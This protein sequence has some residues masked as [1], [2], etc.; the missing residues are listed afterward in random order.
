MTARKGRPRKPPKLAPVQHKPGRK[1]TRADAVR[2]VVA[3][4]PELRR[5]PARV[6]VLASR[7]GCTVS[8]QAA[9]DA[10]RSS[11]VQGRP[12]MDAGHVDALATVIGHVR[13]LLMPLNI[14]DRAAV[15]EMLGL[16]D[17]AKGC[18]M[19]RLKGGE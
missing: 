14:S 12:R 3:A 8:R 6:A 5:K 9:A 17:R 16:C 4:H 11:A 19:Q 10:M 18:D 7:D 15:L 2:A 13:A 1:P